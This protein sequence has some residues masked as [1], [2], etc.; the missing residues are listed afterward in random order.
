MHDVMRVQTITRYHEEE[1]LAIRDLIRVP[2]LSRVPM[3][4]R[5]IGRRQRHVIHDLLLRFGWE[6]G[7]DGNI[8]ALLYA[9]YFEPFSDVE[10]RKSNDCRGH[11][12][13]ILCSVDRHSRNGY[14][15]W[16]IYR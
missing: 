11:E 9:E 6:R 13:G 14:P 12:A 16:H 4:Q 2:D 8:R 7:F 5:D 15:R 1:L 3:R 10:V